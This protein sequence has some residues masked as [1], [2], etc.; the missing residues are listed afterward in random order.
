M[1]RYGTSIGTWLAISITPVSF[2]ATLLNTL[3][4]PGL[5]ALSFSSS[6]ILFIFVDCFDAGDAAYHVADVIL[7]ERKEE[8]AKFA[9]W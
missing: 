2:S 5:G 9:S 6:S 7:H 3:S 1:A 8:A 4:L